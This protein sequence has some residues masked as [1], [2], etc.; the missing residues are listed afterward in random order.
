MITPILIIDEDDFG[1]IKKKQNQAHRMGF[2][3]LLNSLS[4]KSSGDLRNIHSS[5]KEA[6]SNSNSNVYG[7]IGNP[8]LT[9]TL[10]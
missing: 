2:T 7:S 1:Y 8:N 10:P 9:L 6:N 5:V 3:R 4:R